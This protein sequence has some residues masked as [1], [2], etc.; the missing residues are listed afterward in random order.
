MRKIRGQGMVKIDALVAAA[1]ATWRCQ[2]EG[3][4]ADYVLTWDDIEVPA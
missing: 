1:I 4:S 3:E 2:M